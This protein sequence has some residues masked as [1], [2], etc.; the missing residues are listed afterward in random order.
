MTTRLLL[1]PLALAL[2]AGCAGSPERPRP[3]PAAAAAPAPPASA[4]DVALLASPDFVVRSRAAE[5]LVDGGEAS[6]PAL[7]AAGAMTVS[8]PGSSRV[9]ATRPVIEA[10]LANTPAEKL[11]A[12]LESPWP[13]VRRGAAEEIGRRGLWSPIPAL[14]ARLED[15]DPSV[16]N[17]A[18]SA[19]R[20]L[21][22]QFIGP[23]SPGRRWE[24]IA[25]AARWREWWQVEGRQR[26]AERRPGGSG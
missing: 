16:R 12:H 15:A 8:A 7:G 9:E 19:L 21:T 13:V 24:C 18:S 17:A 20:R 3:G 22:N 6:L 14:I 4:S 1:A 5:R 2:L 23:A 25:A 26:A 11:P 10:I